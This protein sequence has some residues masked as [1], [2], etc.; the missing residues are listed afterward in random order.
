MIMNKLK[1]ILLFFI[2][3]TLS[4]RTFPNHF[5]RPTTS[6]PPGYRVKTIVIDAGHGGHDGATKGKFSREKDV[7]LEIAL[8]LGKAIEKELKDVKVI[9]TRESDV[10][11]KLYERIACN[12]T[13]VY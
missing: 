9:Y 6:I 13:T 2:T 8:K 5:I 7:A 12:G 1:Y 11:V 4:Q 3:I 10:F